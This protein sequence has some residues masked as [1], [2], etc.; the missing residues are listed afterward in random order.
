M[1]IAQHITAQPTETTAAKPTETEAL[2]DHTVV[3]VADSLKIIVPSER[4]SSIQA[5]TKEQY[6]DVCAGPLS[7]RRP[8]SQS[9]AQQSYV[10]GSVRRQC[11]VNLDLG[12]AL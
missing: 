12:I 3:S 6:V 1:Q 5:A 7:V 4:V 8:M 2:H 11:V 10:H 9:I